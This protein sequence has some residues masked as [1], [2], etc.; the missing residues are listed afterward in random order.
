MQRNILNNNVPRRLR[1][2]QAQAFRAKKFQL[3]CNSNNIKL[4][5][6][7]VDDH[8]AIG[9]VERMIQTLKRIQAVMRIDKTNTTYRLASDVAEIIKTLRIT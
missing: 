3:F 9:V 1:C 7:P 5:F 4:L 6:A 8:R 2:D